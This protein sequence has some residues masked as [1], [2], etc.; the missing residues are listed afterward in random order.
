MTIDNGTSDRAAELA[1]LLAHELNQPLAQIAG[2][3]EL[4]RL[5]D[6]T[7]DEHDAAVDI[8]GRS[9]V[10][11]QQV[12]ARLASVRDGADVIGQT[13]PADLAALAREVVQELDRTVLAHHPTSVHGPAQ[14]VW[15]VDPVA[16][17]QVLL[18]L[19]SNAAA[20]SPEGRAITI[21]IAPTR[22]TA[23]LAVRDEG[24]G[25]APEDAERI[26]EAWQRGHDSHAGLGLGLYLSRRI[27]RAHG[28]DL[29]LEAAPEQGSM[30]V[31]ELPRPTA[32]RNSG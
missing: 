13:G 24:R 30:F 6:V 20:Y 22:D 16:I 23:R 21:E 28:G 29:Y 8:M 7:D 26:F 11:A 27:A 12:V 31:L 4:L 19:L 2:A 3:V 15:T 18:N 5:D 14:L 25:V 17:R 1:G 9:V 10:H 32:S